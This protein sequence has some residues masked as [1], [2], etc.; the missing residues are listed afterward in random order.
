[1]IKA[2]GLFS[3]GLDSMLAVKLML[4]QGLAVDVLHYQLGFECPKLTR[5]IRQQGEEVSLAE[6]ERQL[7]VTIRQVD[8]SQA[9]LPVV[10]HPA[11]G[12]GAAINPCVDC[13]IFMLQQAK[14]Y[15]ET[16]GAQFVFTGEVLGQRPMSQHRET[17]RQIEKASGLAGYLLRPLSAKLFEPTIPEQQGW[18]DRE[19]LLAIS[20]RS[21]TAQRQLARQYH[22]RFPQPA[23]GCLL[24][25]LN[26]A[27]RFEDLRAHKAEAEIGGEDVALLKFG[28][29]F[30]LADTLKVIVG[31]HELDNTFLANY[32]AGR[33]RAEVRDYQGPLAIID[34][35]PT[36]AQWALIA[37]ILVS[38][39]KGKQAAQV[40]VDCAC[41]EAQRALTIIP[42]AQLPVDQ[43]RIG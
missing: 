10:L 17:L 41:G 13:K 42:D 25:D 38:Y 20:G 11:H 4:D 5:R 26:F 15:M 6:V 7:G 3:G 23:G 9:F 33:W 29:H 19:R 39:T 31:R 30:R 28:R 16:H 8:V 22:L 40:T 27:K 14:N 35:I 2:V 43:W 12:Y 36:D 37:Q 18:V 32:T 24:T 34:G 1:M 21:R